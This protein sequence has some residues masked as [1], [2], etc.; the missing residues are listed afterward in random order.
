MY[1][2]DSQPL[3]GS[4][5]LGTSVDHLYRRGAVYW[6]QRRL[7]VSLAVDGPRRVARSLLTTDPLLARRLARACSAAFDRAILDLMSK[8]SPSREDLVGVLDDIFRRVLQD[9][10]RTRAE[11][12]A[13]PPEWLP[14]PA[15]DPRYEGLEPEQW[16][17]VD[18]PPEEWIAEWRH[19]VM[20]NTVEDVLPMVIDALRARDL[21]HGARHPSRPAS[22]P[23]LPHRR[24]ARSFHQRTS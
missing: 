16:N 5:A 23:A 18:Y 12:A 22:V 14:D 1:A 6:W 4:A 20:T 2:T 10:E 15:T 7:P 11:R 24:R 9:G 3:A 19:A 17:D 21:D 13:G 8:D